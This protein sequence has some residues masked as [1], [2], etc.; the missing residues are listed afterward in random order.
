MLYGFLGFRPTADGY[1]VHP[2]LP[3]DWPSLSING[4][5]FQNQILDITAHA[6]GRV[7]ANSRTEP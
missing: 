3:K 1:Q 5:R 6:N 7:E 2:R 4:I